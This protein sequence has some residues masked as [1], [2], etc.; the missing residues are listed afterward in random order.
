MHSRGRSRRSKPTRRSPYRRRSKPTRRSPYRRRSKRAEEGFTFR[1]VLSK[2][3]PSAQEDLYAQYEQLPPSPLFEQWGDDTLYP[4]PSQGGIQGESVK[5]QCGVKCS[6]LTICTYQKDNDSLFCITHKNHANESTQEYHKNDKIHKLLYEAEAM[7]II[8]IR[9][10]VYLMYRNA[11][12][13]SSKHLEENIKTDFTKNA[14]KHLD[15]IT[16]NLLPHWDTAKYGNKPESADDLVTSFENWEPKRLE[17]VRAKY[18]PSSYNWKIA[19][20]VNI[21]DKVF[22][23]R[24]QG[25]DDET[26]VS[27]AYVKPSYFAMPPKTI[28]V[29]YVIRERPCVMLLKGSGLLRNMEWSCLPTQPVWDLLAIIFDG[30]NIMFTN[31][32]SK[33]EELYGSVTLPLASARTAILEEDER[34]GMEQWYKSDRLL[35]SKY[36]AE[37]MNDEFSEVMFIGD[38]T[39]EK[40]KFKIIVKDVFTLEKTNGILTSSITDVAFRY[41]HNAE[42]SQITNQK[43]P[44]EVK[45]RLLTKYLEQTKKTLVSFKLSE[46]V[47]IPNETVFREMLN[48]YMELTEL[49]YPENISI[50]ILR[51]VFK[52]VVKKEE[53]ET[54]SKAVYASRLVRKVM[55]TSNVKWL[56]DN[57][58]KEKTLQTL[59]VLVGANKHVMKSQLPKYVQDML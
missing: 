52:E 46:P 1:S 12:N 23:L 43:T 29:N 45:K 53:L 22:T 48:V 47:V 10:R 39:I 21:E 8:P 26:K 6:D 59:R 56:G 30:N 35:K 5:S 55:D 15:Y 32:V 57:T 25:F 16:K 51:K 7:R 50:D 40:Q 54:H 37:Y 58:I 3:D 24:F 34:F 19:T 49:G 28:F 41:H 14:Q 38:A 31:I 11:L 4:P 2:P 13:H 27:R 33:K 36:F 20:I 17:L 44:S 42:V 18:R 9:V